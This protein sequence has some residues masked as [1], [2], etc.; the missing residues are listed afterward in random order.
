MKKKERIPLDVSI[1]LRY[2][3]QDRG[4]KCSKL[5][6]KFPLYSARSIYRHAN[7][8]IGRKSYDKRKM[9]TGR[10]PVLSQRDERKIINTVTKLRNE[11]GHFTSKRVKLEAGIENQTSIRTVRRC[12]NR[13]G[14]YYRHSRKKGLLTKD[15]MKTRKKFACKV[16]KTLPENLWTEGIGFYFDGV[17]FCHKY[18]PRDQAMSTK[19]MAW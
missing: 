13:F 12:L 10:P 19:T 11:V 3:H 17:G 14:F 15:D 16:I 1:Y 6:K 2:L 9:N 8:P 5:V 18:N 7:L 4:D